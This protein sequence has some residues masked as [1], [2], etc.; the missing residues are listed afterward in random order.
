MSER[1]GPSAGS[2]QVQVDGS[3]MVAMLGWVLL[4]IGVWMI[5]PAVALSVGG[6]ILLA[7]GLM[8]AWLKGRK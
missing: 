7:V 4:M 3:D 6:G 5:S 2:G 1:K 8:G